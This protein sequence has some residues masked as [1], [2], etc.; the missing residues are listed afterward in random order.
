MRM[1][2]AEALVRV[3][4]ARQ[5]ARALVA[6]A[7]PRLRAIGSQTWSL[8]AEDLARR[9]GSGPAGVTAAAP[10]VLTP[11][12]GEVL[13]LLADGRSNRAIAGALVISEATAVR[14]VANIYAKLRVHSRAQATRVALERGLIGASPPT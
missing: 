8:H 13:A 10:D 4:G 1:V 9:L 11:R 2:A 12:E 14:H 5:E 7:R 3:R 6:G